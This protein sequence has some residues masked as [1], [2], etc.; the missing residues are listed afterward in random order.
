MNWLYAA[1]LQD[2]ATF[3]CMNFH[4]LRAFERA[5]LNDAFEHFNSGLRGDASN[6]SLCP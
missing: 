6:E 5:H 1:V 3:S 2:F 4:C